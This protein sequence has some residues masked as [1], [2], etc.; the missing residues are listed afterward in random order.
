[1]SAVAKGTSG[2]LVGK[3]AMITG[4]SRG[5]GLAI[6][7]RFAAEGAKLI[8]VAS[9]AGQHGPLKNTLEAVVADFN[10]QGYSAAMEVCD[11][12]KAEQRHDLV[13]RAEAHFGPLD[14]VVNNAAAMVSKLPS[15]L[16]SEER[17]L[18]QEVN[19]NA[20]IEIAQQALNSG[21]RER[22]GWILNI[23][24]R[25]VEQ[26][27]APYPDSA[28][29]AHVVGGYGASKAAL[30]RYSEALAHEVA[31]DGVYVN[32]LAPCNIVLT[33]AAAM[34]MPI[35]EKNPNM[36]EPIEMMAEAALELCSA[37][38]VGQCVYSRELVH[39]VGRPLKSL[40]G[41]EVIGDAFSPADL[42]IH[43]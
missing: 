4:A 16:S 31:A 24:S 26:P 9:R 21:M 36:V 10:A 6:A 35:A 14:I 19:L 39:A 20:P 37:R 2:E 38:H 43:S 41:S 22:G 5:I 23:S 30:N 18:M 34:V 42:S 3:T 25:T 40:D 28:I 33:S 15:Q 27:L 32:T 1:M 11:L 17:Q 8:L 7:K 29:A 13:A 12:R